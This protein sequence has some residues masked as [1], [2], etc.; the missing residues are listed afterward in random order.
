M[1]QAALR[2]VFLSTLLTIALST[3]SLAQN[4]SSDA[5]RIGLGG[6]GDSQNTASRLVEE[7]RDYKSI[8]DSAWDHSGREE[9]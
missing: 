4:F 1:N 2:N 7:Q 8:P 3:P 9:S 6:A 5:R